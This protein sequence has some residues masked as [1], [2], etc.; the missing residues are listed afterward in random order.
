MAF[1]AE[2]KI[3][4]SLTGF[5]VVKFW[6]RLFHH[7]LLRPNF[8][9]VDQ[10][11]HINTCLDVDGLSHAAIDG[12]AAEDVKITAFS[13]PSSPCNRAQQGDDK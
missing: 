10:E 6:F 8:L 11:Q 12:L 3:P 5:F 7:N 1:S 13:S 4:P 9:P 2:K